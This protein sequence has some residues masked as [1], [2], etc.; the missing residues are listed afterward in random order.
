MPE[1]K[2]TFLAGKMNKSLDDRLVPEGE[3][4]DAQNIEV[5]TD[6]DGGGDIGTLRRIKG[7]TALFDADPDMA[8]QSETIGSF[9]D[10]KNNCIYYFVTNNGTHKIYK[11]TIGDDNPIVIAKGSYL[12]FNKD[13]LITGVNILDNFLFWTDDLNP[14]RRLDLSKVVAPNYDYY[15]DLTDETKVSVAKYSPYLA[16]TIVLGI[17]PNVDND[18]IK[19]KF[20]RFSYRYKYNDG[21]YSQLAPFSPIAF[22]ALTNTEPR[23]TSAQV[24]KA[25]EQGLVEYFVNKFNTVN[26]SAPLPTDPIDV[27]GIESVEFLIKDDNS[28]AVRIVKKK[29]V[30]NNADTTSIHLYKS[31][32][33]I[34][35]LP[36]KELLRVSENAPIKAKS[37]EIVG[38]RVVYGNFVENY[39]LP[40]LDYNLS[41]GGK[42]TNAI[43]KYRDQSIKQRRTYE[44]GIVLSDKYGRKSPVILGENP[45]IHVPAK[46]SNFDATNWSGDCLKIAFSSLPSDWGDWYSYRVVI[47]QPQQEYYNVY[48]P[49]LSS[50]NG[51]TYF[52]TF[53]DNVNKVPR[54]S[55][56]LTFESEISTSDTYVYPKVINGR[57][58]TAHVENKQDTNLSRT[59]YN[60]QIPSGN[61]VNWSYWAADEGHYVIEEITGSQTINIPGGSPVGGLTP[62][63]E[64]VKVYVD[65]LLASNILHYTKSG[66]PDITSI[67]F[68]TN[69]T[70]PAGRKITIFKK[71]RFNGQAGTSGHVIKALYYPEGTF[72][73]GG[74]VQ[75]TSEEFN[76]YTY[77]GDGT[78]PQYPTVDGGDVYQT[79]S[80]GGILKVQGIGT[81]NSF[82]DITDTFIEASDSENNRGFYKAKNNYLVASIADEIGL[83]LTGDNLKITGKVHDLAVLETKPFESALDI[84]YETATTGLV[85]DLNTTSTI[86]IDYY[87]T[88]IIYGDT[89][90]GSEPMWHVEES[91]IKGDFNA[92]SVGYGVVAYTTNPDYAQT[93]RENTLIYSGIYNPRTGFNETNQFPQGENITKS[94]DLQYGSIQ[95]L[96][97]EE[98]DLIVFQ[99]EKVSNIPVDRDIIYTAEGIPQVVTSNKVFGDPMAYLGNYGIGTN[100]ESFA[101]YAGRKYFV[102]RPKGAV[103]RLSRDGI[104]EI[105]NY[106]MRTYFVNQLSLNVDPG[107]QILRSKAFG[108]WDM[109]KRQYVLHSQKSYNDPNSMLQVI[110]DDT[111]T[112]SFDENAQGWVSFYDY[113]PQTGGSI[114]GKFYT[115]KGSKIYE[116]HKGTSFYGGIDFNASVELVMNQ[117]PSASKNF[118]SINYEGTETWNITTIETDTDTASVI[119]NYDNTKQDTENDIYLNRFRNFDGKYFANII[120]NSPVND[121]EVSFGGDISGV[122]GHF[123]KLKAYTSDAS[124][125]LFSISTNY[126][127]NSY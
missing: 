44:V 96:F 112:L 79:L 10:D 29:Q 113:D 108:M 84:Y 49:G 66:S 3:Y 43:S 111:A 1:I 47:K 36:E 15:Y 55:E 93:R 2:H 34:S 51:I 21:T 80:D 22:R 41:V 90:P 18:Y 116:Q 119:F 86:P 99:E 120:N 88:F 40:S 125:E 60:I 82:S 100:P 50:F 63:V 35:T 58:Y 32:I 26:I 94:L 67:S 23:L 37:Q 102:D 54:N 123:L 64:D 83:A 97:A 124:A 95:K 106:G 98:R 103:L 72:S 45:N 101:Y 6:I 48:L 117:N 30:A 110:F 12:G 105:S 104:T 25:Y 70:Q 65:G 4:R 42:L 109:A 75:Q 115:F 28:S 20:V 13:Y 78:T 107:Y 118:L 71:L 52:T 68:T 24:T 31:E 62:T 53:G 74:A 92:D 89:P 77:T 39:D 114:D 38:N 87:N 121:N 85:S 7:N 17:D 8:F 57:Y 91:R 122:K 126:N 69:Y 56:A 81:L 33:P 46:A 16:P 76:I 27:H 59:S 14:P 11:Y 61:S 73:G 127:V 9:F 19:E 5:T